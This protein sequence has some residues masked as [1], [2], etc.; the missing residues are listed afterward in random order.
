MQFMQQN[1][2]ANEDWTEGGIDWTLDNVG[3]VLEKQWRSGSWVI[4]PF[5]P[6]CSFNLS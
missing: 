2:S 6:Q 5:T 3:A 4:H 1:K